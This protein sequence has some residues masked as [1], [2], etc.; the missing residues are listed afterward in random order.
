MLI[1]ALMVST[2][3]QLLSVLLAPFSALLVREDLTTVLLV[4]KDQSLLMELALLSVDRTPSPS[5]ATV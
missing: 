5:K 2:R 1:P 3:F 4:F